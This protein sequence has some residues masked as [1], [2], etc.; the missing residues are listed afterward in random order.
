VI[1]NF[2]HPSNSIRVISVKTLNSIMKKLII[3]LF[4]ALLFIGCAEDTNWNTQDAVHF[5]IDLPDTWTMEEVQGYDSFVRQI[6]ISEQQVISI[7][8]GWYSNPL[9]VD[10]TTHTIQFKTIDNKDAKIV[11]AKDFQSGTTGVYFELIDDNNNRLNISGQD[12]SPT[13]QSLLLNAI[14]TIRFQ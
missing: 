6:R 12:L 13:N 10:A 1:R 14:E 7:D 4:A 5:T 3:A 2:C 11:K 9:N 8:L